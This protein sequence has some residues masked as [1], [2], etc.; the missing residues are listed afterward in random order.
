M[1]T[2]VLPIT[3][4]LSLGAV[5][6]L[7]AVAAFA[8]M[9]MEPSAT[10]RELKFSHGFH[11]EQGITCDQCHVN[12]KTS[13]TGKDD[14]LPGHAQCSQ[15][16]DV[17]KT[18]ECSTCHLSQAPKP[19]AR[20]VDYS[21][22]F[23]H[24]RHIEQGKLECTLCH[25]NLD[26]ALTPHQMGHGPNMGECMTCHDQQLVKND[27]STCHLPT[28]KLKPEDH[29]LNWVYRHGMA[30]SSMTD[31]RC[32]MCH[33][34][35]QNAAMDCNRCHN[36]DQITNPHPRDYV[37]RHGAD[38]HLS[39]VQCNVCHEVSYCNDCHAQRQLVPPSHFKPNWANRTTGGDHKDRA[40]F[41]LE[42]CMSCH[43]RPNAEPVC[44][45]CH[46]K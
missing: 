28:D 45:Q 42:S 20:I 24:Q 10:R 5:C 19:S 37:T 31:V 38:A 29:N 30:A 25:T 46:G 4:I 16:H 6:L 21:P 3:R 34:T 17:Q 11:Q 2:R 23:S 39:D 35:N 1:K 41:D 43:D 15:C 33:N 13:A 9:K 18:T 8:K 22:K 44:V 36:G 7:L 40:E 26:S 14:L 27:C 12:A 32:M